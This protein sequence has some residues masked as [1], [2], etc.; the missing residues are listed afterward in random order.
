MSKNK[1]YG[2]DVWRRN[3]HGLL[4]SVEYEF[5]QDGSVNW[6]A[7]IDPEHLYPNKD[8]FEM[9]KMPVPDSIEG[10]DDSQLLIKLSGIKELARLRGFHNLTYDI[11]ESSDSRVVAQCMINWI[12]N[13]DSILLNDKNKNL[14]LAVKSL[15]Y[16]KILTYHNLDMKSLP[17]NYSTN[18]SSFKIL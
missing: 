9:R 17:D 5:N 15:E 10:L 14:I 4:E 16:V 1:L 12:E 18:I 3:E 13:Y 2:P 8:W 7:M 11:T 6:R